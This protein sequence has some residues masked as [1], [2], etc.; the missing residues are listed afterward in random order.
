MGLGNY[1]R[2]SHEFNLFATRGTGVTFDAT[3]RSWFEAPRERHSQKP[4]EMRKTIESVSPGPYLELFGR[5]Q[6]AGWTVIGD[7]ANGRNRCQAD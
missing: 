4:P 6:V 5:R 1:Y 2:V 3:V 7:Q